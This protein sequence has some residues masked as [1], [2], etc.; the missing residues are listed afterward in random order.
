[1]IVACL[2]LDALGIEIATRVL[3]R[4]QLTVHDSDPS[5]VQRLTAL[6]AASVPDAHAVTA[7]CA[8]VILSLA[9]P[10]EARERLLGGG[11]GLAR[12]LRPGTLVIDHGPG[13]PESTRALAA[14]LS[15]LGIGLVDAPIF[16]TPDDVRAGAATIIAGAPATRLEQVRPVLEAVT[17]RIL[18]SGEVGTATTM[19][20]I[21]GA[22][23]GSHRALSI[24]AL[25]LASIR[26]IEPARAA[27]IAVA[28]SGRNHYLSGALESGML[29]GRSSDPTSLGEVRDDVS[30]ACRLAATSGVPMFLGNR[31][32][33]FY[34]ACVREL[35][36]HVAADA[37]AKVMDRLSGS[38]VAPR[39]NS[40]R[41]A[42]T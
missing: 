35:G 37:A 12:S 33:A 10:T 2:G 38:R 5:R 31:I 17:P 29:T 39:H 14:E 23:A 28:G 1:V 18:H 13:E 9:S 20:I 41:V 8:V 21:A 24:E 19:R 36:I 26:G 11:G 40:S 30:A 3:D 25:A 42:R 32:D 22:L 27:E 16:G 7:E 15:Q 34:Q 6:G 4:H